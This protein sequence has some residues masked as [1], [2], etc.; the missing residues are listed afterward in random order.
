MIRE[1]FTHIAVSF[2]IYRAGKKLPV[3]DKCFRDII[4]SSVVDYFFAN[5][6]SVILSKTFLKIGLYKT[7]LGIMPR[8]V[9]QF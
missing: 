4:E 1:M 7:G 2:I 5:H 9:S 3:F 8:P 6:R